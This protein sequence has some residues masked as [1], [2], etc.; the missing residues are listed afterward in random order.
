MRCH[1]CTHGQWKD[2]QYLLRQN[3]QKF[4]FVSESHLFERA[5][6]ETSQGPLD[7]ESQ[8]GSE[9]V[10]S[11]M[12]EIWKRW[13]SNKA[14]KITNRKWKNTRNIESE[15]S[16]SFTLETQIQK[17]PQNLAANTKSFLFV[18]QTCNLQFCIVIIMELRSKTSRMGVQ[19]EPQCKEPKGF[20]FFGVEGWAKISEKVLRGFDWS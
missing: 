18:K 20:C 15:S 10:T 13:N 4:L 14:P 7:A 8:C 1:V 11:F 19:S 17:L 3:P 6:V 12:P 9:I 5:D 2:V 16:A